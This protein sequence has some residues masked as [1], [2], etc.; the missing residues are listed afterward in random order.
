MEWVGSFFFVHLATKASHFRFQDVM[1]SSLEDALATGRADSGGSS[2]ISFRKL[3]SC[4]S[5]LHPANELEEAT[6]WNI[7]TA[8][9]YTG[10]DTEYSEVSAAESSY[11]PKR[12]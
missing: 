5:V 9:G 10:F 2:G 7:G 1:K 8:D 12:M 11:H 4:Q 6:V 3:I